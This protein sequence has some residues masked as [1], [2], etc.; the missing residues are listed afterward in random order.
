MN[1]GGYP[2]SAFFTAFAEMAMRVWALHC[3]AL[4]FEE[5]VTIFQVKKN[6]RFSEVYMECVTEEPVSAASWESSD[7]DSGE[8][9]V[10]FTVVPGFKMGK[11]VIQ[12]QVYVS[13][14][15]SSP[16]SS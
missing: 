15:G 10:G 8:L 2:D 5:D 1:S 14:V 16:A 3:L 13:L 12:S 6:T 9:R 4:S 11:T 7:S